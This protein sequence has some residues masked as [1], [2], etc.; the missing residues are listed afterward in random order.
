MYLPLCRHV[1]C[2]KC[3]SDWL[4][5]SVSNNNC[6]ID[7]TQIKISKEEVIKK[8]VSFALQNI[9]SDQIVMCKY[10]RLG[11]TRT[12][13]LSAFSDHLKECT[14]KPANAADAE[15]SFNNLSI[16]NNSTANVNAAPA[17][18]VPQPEEAIVP[19]VS[20]T[21]NVEQKNA[22][23]SAAVSNNTTPNNNKK[24]DKKS[25]QRNLCKKNH[26]FKSNASVY[27]HTGIIFVIFL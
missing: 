14:F 13:T 9:I 12:F 6:P 23:S 10:K 26:P 11:C 2:S 16:D 27:V 5:Q 8:R 7:K 17:A 3:I 18:A 4:N 20:N 21:S 22:M 24:S 19:N 25:K 1:F 15:T